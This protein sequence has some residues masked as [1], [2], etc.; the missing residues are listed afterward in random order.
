M[1][2]PNE[3]WIWS[4]WRRYK[5]SFTEED[6]RK[7]AQDGAK[8]MDEMEGAI[9]ASLRRL[10]K[11]LRLMVGV[12]TDYCS[13]EYRDISWASLCAV[14]FAMAYWV[15]PLDAIPDLAPILGYVDDG[16]VIAFVLKRLQGE[17]EKYRAWR[18]FK[19]SVIDVNNE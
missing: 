5:A 10:W 3:S 17:L 9:P 16:A 12:L 14:A 8:R 13:G 11:D 4:F 6:A 18:E 15:L 1:S 19:E 2:V 7:A